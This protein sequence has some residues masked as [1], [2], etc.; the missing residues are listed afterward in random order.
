MRRRPVRCARDDG[1]RAG[2]AATAWPVPGR[3][4]CLLQPSA[5]ADAASQYIDGLFNDSERKSMQAMHGR[6][7]DPQ[8]YQALQHFITHSP[9]DAT[10]VWTRLRTTVPM[11]TG[12][13]ALDDMGF[14]KQGTKSPG[15]Q[16]QYCGALGKIGNCQV[17]VSSALIADGRTWPLAF[18]LYLPTSWTD[19]AARCAAAGIPATV[20]FREKWRIALAQVRTVLQAGFTITGVV[21]DADAGANAAFR[22][23]LERLGLAYGVAIRG[24]ATF[25]VTGVPGTLSAT[26]L[27]TSAPDDAWESVTWGTG[28]AGPLTARFCA[29]RVRPTKGRGDRWLLCE[30]SATDERKYYLLHLPGTTALVDLV[31]LARSRWPIEQQYRELK[32]DLGLDHFEGRTYQ[33]WAHHVVLTAVAFTFLQIE[34]GRATVEPRPTLPVVRGWVREIM[35]LLYVIHN[36]RLLSML[37]SFRRNAPLRR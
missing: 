12:I 13:L 3:L 14:P 2:A 28:T 35:S 16:R 23:G 26:A 21:V 8:D 5:A 19:D 24:E 10:R 22:A 30:R 20:R 34:R 1:P 7:G 33:G 27:A 25:A 37:D 11:R 6:L 31:A 17:A 29:L 36:R 4:Q 32:D 15:V 9:W 18:D